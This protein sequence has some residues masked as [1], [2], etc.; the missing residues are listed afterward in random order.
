MSAEAWIALAVAL[1]TSTITVATCAAILS[2][3]LS[4]IEAKLDAVTKSLD[5]CQ[6]E[7]AED[8]RR[9]WGKADEH[10]ERIAVLESR[11]NN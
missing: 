3:R 6:N 10:G 8:S 5:K 7:E 11:L 2:S 9:L 1:L 4:K